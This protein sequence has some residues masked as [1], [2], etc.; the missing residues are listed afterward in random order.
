MQKEKKEK[1]EK[2]NEKNEK[3]IKRKEEKKKSTSELAREKKK[4]VAFN[5]GKEVPYPL[6][7]SKKDK[8]HHLVRFL[9]IFR[10]IEI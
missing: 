10:K 5:E 7:P 8:E 3:E 1:K 2:D 9:D 4:E 6:V